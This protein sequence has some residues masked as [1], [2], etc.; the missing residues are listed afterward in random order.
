MP[1]QRAADYGDVM[2]AYPNLLL[3]GRYRLLR[4]LGSGGEGQVWLGHVEGLGTA[5][6]VKILHSG[7]AFV[8]REGHREIEALC[9][10][11]HPRIVPLLDAGFDR[12]Q[13]YLVLP[14]IDALTLREWLTDRQALSVEATLRLARE[15]VTALEHAHRAGVL[16][17]DLK[18][19]NIFLTGDGA[20]LSD[21]GAAVGV[22]NTLSVGHPGEL[23]G[24]MAYLAPEVL[25]GARPSVASDIYSLG[26]VLY[27]SLTGSLPW[28]GRGGGEVA[29][30]R[31]SAPLPSVREAR[32]DIPEA[33]DAAIQKA[34]SIE[35][36]QR[37]RSAAAFAAALEVADGPTVRLAPRPHHR[38][39]PKP[40]GIPIVAA[41]VATLLVLSVIAG[42]TADKLNGDDGTH[43]QT[44]SR[45]DTLSSDASAMSTS[46]L[47]RI[48]RSEAIASSAATAVP[49]ASAIT[50]PP[51]TST[52]DP[53]P[54]AEP[55]V[56]PSPVASGDQPAAQP[57]A[58]Q[59]NGSQAGGNGNSG[60][61]NEKPDKPAKPKKAR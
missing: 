6:A 47:A 53:T 9:R 28:R 36:S 44:S 51:T 11:Q 22:E 42:V 58:G 57:A 8:G 45:G 54:E 7:A 23:A 13:R 15:V 37:F 1:L 50:P 4:L 59:N 52:S 26:L 2:D 20:L 38:A 32:P 34:L 21:F 56:T 61:G 24:T 31:L 46:F 14:F 29:V 33:L 27:E 16:H 40:R 60:R 48:L 17:N 10:L 39:S 18:P 25:A 30:H 19:S 12:G 5:V 35:P 3:G 41:L 55:A 49:E 43:D